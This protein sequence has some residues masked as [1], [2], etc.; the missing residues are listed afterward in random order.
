MSAKRLEDNQYPTQCIP[1]T[2][3]RTHR[4]YFFSQD[5]II[6]DKKYD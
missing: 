5:N 3:S 6:N 4:I 2:W 1:E